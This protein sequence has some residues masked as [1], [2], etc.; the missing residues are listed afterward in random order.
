M[1]EKMISRINVEIMAAAKEFGNVSNETHQ[2]NMAKIHGMVAMLSI[3]TEKDYI[4]T[5]NGLVEK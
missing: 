4:I 2:R 3:V 5:E 1:E